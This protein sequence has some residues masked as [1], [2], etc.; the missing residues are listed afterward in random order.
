[1]TTIGIPRELKDQEKRVA[2]T[3][4]GTDVL[5]RAGHR[6]VV[7]AGAGLGSGF[8]DRAFVAA[9]ATV[10]RDACDVW[11]AATLIVKVKE[12]LPSE[13]D[14]FRADHVLFTYLH[15]AGVDPCLTD[16]LME[17]RVTALAYETLRLP[18]GRLPLLEPMSA[19][20]G[21]LATQVGAHYLEAPAGG[22]GVLLGGVPGVRRANVVIIGAG[23]VGRN[24]AQIAAGMGANVLVL[25][26][27]VG[28]LSK[29]EHQFPGIGTQMSS[30]S[31]VAEAVANA[32]VL[33][34]A[35]LVVGARAP[36]VVSREVVASMR[37]GSVIV[38][39][40]VDQGGCVATIRPTSHTEPTYVACDVVHYAVP[41]MPG[42]VP[43]TSTLALT[44]ATLPYIVQLAEQGVDKALAAAPELCEA[45]NVRDGKVVHP[46][47]AQALKAQ[48]APAAAGR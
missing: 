37:P 12:P 9:G 3:P 42:A 15:L 39:V 35:V 20:A 1:V 8:D 22:S 38:D 40:A 31:A 44:N 10:L 41:N 29:L 4:S 45:L 16:R 11:Q 23:T 14:Y 21:R 25:N 34:G 36:R 46:A 13:Y 24:A 43:H 30:P 48:L 7:E 32:D 26:R 19:I 33:I 28:A 5:V 18:D 2:L 6:V 17:Q 27:S 47:V